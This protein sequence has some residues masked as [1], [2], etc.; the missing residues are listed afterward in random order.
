MGEKQ[1]FT[2]PA[3]LTKGGQSIIDDAMMSKDCGIVLLDKK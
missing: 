2:T 3:T 1:A